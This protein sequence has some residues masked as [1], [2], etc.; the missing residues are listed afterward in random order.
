MEKVRIC[1]VGAGRAGMVHAKN[2]VHRISH[3]KLVALVDNNQ[4]ALERS[5]KEL[6][7][8]DLYGDYKE[9]LGRD[10][11]DAAIIVTPTFTHQE[12]ACF[13]ALNKK[14]V[15]LEK[16]MALT[17]E[18]CSNINKATKKNAVKLQIGFMRRFD[19]AFTKAKAIIDTG[20]MGRV[21]IIKS[22]G[23]G[24]GLPPPWANDISR[25]NGMLAE[26][27]SHDFDSIRWLVGSEYER[28][29]AQAGNFKCE[30]LREDY[31]DF[32]DN[33]VVNVR[34]K[35]GTLGLVDGT[36]PV[37]YGYDARVEILC[38]KGML[39]I[40]DFKEPGFTW[41]NTDGT[42]VESAFRSWRD[43]F[44][45]AYLAEMEH[46][47]GAIIDQSEPCVTGEDGKKVVEVVIAANRSIQTGQPIE[48]A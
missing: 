2:V 16:P 42:T 38:E 23:R 29:F 11:V 31:P 20:E 34:F 28:V 30:E 41:V 14:H 39:H 3:A 5:G 35:N 46:F 9:A 17:K 10:D 8:E 26:V 12:I 25:S 24:P 22:T 40:G 45:D 21:M 27:N 1:L 13:A 7:I 18:E 47:V 43:R 4:D 32:Y 48:L 6:G 19:M 44:K 37:G 15:F 33:A 36:C